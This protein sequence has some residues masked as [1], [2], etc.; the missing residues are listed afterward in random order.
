MEDSR[1]RQF[2]GRHDCRHRARDRVRPHRLCDP[3][4]LRGRSR[5]REPVR[6]LVAR[7]RR[8]DRKR[9]LAFPDRASRPV[10]PRSSGRAES[11][12]CHAWLAACGRCRADR[13][14]GIR[15]P[16]RSPVGRAPFRR[17]G[18]RGS[19]VRF[20]G[21]ACVANAALPEQAR[22]ICA[23]IH[24][25]RLSRRADSRVARRGVAEARFAPTRRA[26]HPAQP[27]RHRGASRF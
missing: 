24:D 18:A 14:D 17:R 23:A 2:L 16:L 20:A 27:A 4:L 9:T 22:A 19:R 1:R 7:A 13:K 3:G 5:W 8:A 21:R 25:R 12:D 10:G 6:Q 26:L 11:R 15:L